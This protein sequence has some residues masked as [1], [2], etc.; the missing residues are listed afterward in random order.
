MIRFSLQ[1]DPVAENAHVRVFVV[2]EKTECGV[3]IMTPEQ[4]EAFRCLLATGKAPVTLGDVPSAKCSPAPRRT[5]MYCPTC[6]NEMAYQHPWQGNVGVLA[7]M[8][9][10]SA[11][12]CAMSYTPEEQ[13]LEQPLADAARALQKLQAPIL[14]RTNNAS[15]WSREHLDE[16]AILY[17]DINTMAVRLLRLSQNVR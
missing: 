7:R 8:R 15:E 6:K 10:R 5:K 4:A 16:L 14:A 11:G 12:H 13:R 2:G 17:V 1:I 3:L 9:T